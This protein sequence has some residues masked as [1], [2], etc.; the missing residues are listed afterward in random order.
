MRH[1]LATVL[2]AVSLLH[3]S[4]FSFND[5][6]LTPERISA[7]L[8]DS[9]VRR[10]LENYFPCDGYEGTGYEQV[11]QGARAWVNVATQLLDHSDACY[12]TGL[13]DALGTAMQ[14]MPEH[15]LPYVG[16]SSQLA[17][18]RICLPFI[19]AEMPRADQLKQLKSA[20]TK[21]QAVRDR[22]LHAQRQAC[23]TE[24]QRVK[25]MVMNKVAAPR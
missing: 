15:V 4:A 24:I 17:A 12:T 21:I 1:L 2:V 11:A 16:L 5:K 18:E 10:V 14:A 6:Q 3:Q 7:E 23:L 8:R 22:R 25:R 20:Q 9:G 19:S 13:Q